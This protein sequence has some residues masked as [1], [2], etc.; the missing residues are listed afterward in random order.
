MDCAKKQLQYRIQHHADLKK[1][2]RNYV[3]YLILHLGSLC[4]VGDW[5]GFLSMTKMKHSLV[6]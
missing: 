4:L 1:K 6:R 2:K 5:G 3:A